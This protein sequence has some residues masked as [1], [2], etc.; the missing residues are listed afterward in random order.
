MIS[1]AYAELYKILKVVN[2]DVRRA[3]FSMDMFHPEALKMERHF[4]GRKWLRKFT[5]TPILL[6]TLN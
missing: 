2:I 1:V 6:W 5:L 4:D 3:L